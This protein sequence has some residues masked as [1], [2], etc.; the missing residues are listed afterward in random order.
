VENRATAERRYQDMI[1]RVLRDRGHSAGFNFLRGG[2]R[3][4]AVWRFRGGR[5]SKRLSSEY[6][7]LGASTKY[8]LN[9]P[10]D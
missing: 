8:G 4:S 10:V 9:I 7:G 2:K 3:V 5:R 1:G 6:C